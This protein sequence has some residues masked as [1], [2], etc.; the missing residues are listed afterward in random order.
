MSFLAFWGTEFYRIPKVVKYVENKNFLVLPL[1]KIKASVNII[2]GGACAPLRPPLL[3]S[4]T[5][6]HQSFN[7]Q[8]LRKMRNLS[9][10]Y[11]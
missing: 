11:I 9:N 1:F 10:V 8:K 5:D 3:V 4:A 2:G 7:P 6:I